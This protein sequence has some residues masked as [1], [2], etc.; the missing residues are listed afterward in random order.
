M[1]IGRTP[2]KLESICFPQC[3]ETKADTLKATEVDRRR[4]PV[5]R[6]KVSSR[7]I[8]LKG[9]THVQESNVGQV[10]VYLV[11]SQLA[12]TLGLSYYC[13]YFLVNKLRD[14]GKIVSAR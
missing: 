2:K 7:R 4:G 13:L 5:T 3:R 6:E 11:L 10:P 14:K 1:R 9:N 8:N 12:K